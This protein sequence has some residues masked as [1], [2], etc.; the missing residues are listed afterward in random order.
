MNG[1][2]IAQFSDLHLSASV[3]D[4][5]LLKIKSKI[6]AYQPD[7]IL[8][9]GD[10]LCFALPRDL[11]RLQL[12][13]SDL[14]APYGCYAV[15]GNHD[16]SAFV[17]VNDRGEYDVLNSSAGSFTRIFERLWKETTLAYKS[18]EKVKTIQNNEILENLLEKTPF[19]LL[20]NESVLIPIKNSFLNITGV[21][22]YITGRCDPTK[23]FKN[24]NKSHP[25]I[26]MAHNPDC[27]P[28]LLNFPGELILCGHT[29]GGQ[30]NLPWLWK[31]F[32]L[33]ENPALKKGLFHLKNKWVYVNRGV[34]SVIPFRWFSIPELLLLTLESLRL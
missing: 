5:F 21:E 12:F 27:V 2:K 19:K 24:F 33:M 11:E 15:L 23:A 1:L 17:S 7:I 4:K 20:K 34:G 9:T 18:T 26:V 3:S 28:S 25:G 8:F 16:Y 22:E 29:H 30:V 14:K 32:T 10:F 6:Q 13:F 31:K